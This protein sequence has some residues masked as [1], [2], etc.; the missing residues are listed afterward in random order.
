ML[1]NVK[2]PKLII[3]IGPTG[4]GKSSLAVNLA[5][6]FNGEVI[7]ADS[8][9]VYKGLNI[10]SGKIT[11]REMK[12]VPHYLLDVASPKKTFTITQYQKL[13][14][15]ALNKIWQKNKLPILCGGTGFYVHA[16]LSG[17]S[18]QSVKPNLKLRRALE[19]L[20][21]QELFN[22]LKKLDLKRAAT[23]QKENK[24]RLIRALEI[25]HE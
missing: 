9:Q 25:I 19:K 4:S 23:I 18:Y 13:A 17:T 10:G 5:R 8:R 11:K 24:R 7:S 20:S 12:G 15:I 14:S 1:N 22:K 16:V 21:A 2:L 6:Q 3:I